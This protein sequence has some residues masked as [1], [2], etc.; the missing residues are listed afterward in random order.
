MITSSSNTN[1][2]DTLTVGGSA[3]S[4]DA[5][6]IQNGAGTSG[7]VGLIYNGSGSLTLSGSNNY[8]GGT[9]IDSGILEF[10]ATN[11]MPSSGT[12]TGSSRG[13]FSE[14]LPRKPTAVDEGPYWHGGDPAFAP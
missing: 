13:L 6:A 10:S 12:V 4:T 8:S 2:I 11:S 7:T 5:G 9:T 3:S 1:S 14:R